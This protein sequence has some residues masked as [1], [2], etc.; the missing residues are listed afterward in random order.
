MTEP[1]ID[2]VLHL[3]AHRCATTTVQHLLARNTDALRRLDVVAWTPDRM[4]GGVFGGLLCGSDKPAA[5]REWRQN[6]ALGLIGIECD[7]LVAQGIG[8]LLVSEQELL[9]SLDA[10]LGA[11]QLY[12]GLAERLARSAPA[13]APRC[14]RIGLAIR[15][16][17]GFW[18][19]AL[20][21]SVAQGRPLPDARA[22][23]AL[24]AQPRR[25]RHVIGDVARAFPQ[26]EIVV[27]PYERFGAQPD[28]VLAHLLGR[29]DVAVS[30]SGARER[31]APGPTL[32]K[33]RRL[34]ALRGEAEAAAALGDD[35]GRWAPLGPVREGALRRDYAHDIAWLRGGAEGL[36]RL[37]ETAPA[38]CPASS[39]APDP[40]AAASYPRPNRTGD[41]SAPAR[42]EITSP[43][44]AGTPSA[45]P[46]E[47]RYNGRAGRVV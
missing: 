42:F 31:M 23:D 43:T 46:A 5:Q 9:G 30:F 26:A 6:R 11:A 15:S 33:L 25:W 17:E 13:L 27:W 47:A 29:P 14:V 18:S 19:S 44:G 39:S 4:R 3:G 41:W 38:P 36:A 10:A 28:V 45:P 37:V 21:S 7:R 8:T 20:A 12:P 35:C 1:D 32:P 22:L 34:L 24:C 2:I 16:Y 40:V